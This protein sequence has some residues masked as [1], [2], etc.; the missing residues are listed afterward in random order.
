LGQAGKAQPEKMFP[1]QL[2]ELTFLPVKSTLVT[3]AS[4]IVSAGAVGFAG[5]CRS[6]FVEKG[7]NG[8]TIGE[9][10]VRRRGSRC[11]YAPGS[12]LYGCSGCTAGGADCSAGI[13]GRA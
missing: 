12:G 8:E 11:V 2:Q 13:E 6:N 9:G 3:Y 7:F 1:L 5:A 10:D 4:A